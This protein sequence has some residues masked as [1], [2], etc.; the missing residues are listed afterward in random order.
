MP[1]HADL[2]QRERH[3]HPDDVQLDQRRHLGTER[4]DERDR[5]EREEQDAVGERQPVTT[6]VQLAR[7]ETVL[8][9]NGSQHREPVERGVGG[10]HQD[11]RGNPGD[12]V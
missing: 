2:T 10:Q 1:D 5:G 3:E 7:Q 4:D 9:E 12:E 11:E 8:R 6:R